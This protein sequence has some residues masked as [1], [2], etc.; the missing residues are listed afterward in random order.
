MVFVVIHRQLL[1]SLHENPVEASFNL[2]PSSPATLPEL[3]VAREVAHKTWP[4]LICEW[5]TSSHLIPSPAMPWQRWLAVVLDGPFIVIDGCWYTSPNWE[6]HTSNAINHRAVW[7]WYVKMNHP[8]ANKPIV[9]YLPESFEFCWITTFV[10]CH[11]IRVMLYIHLTQKS[12]CTADVLSYI[13]LEHAYTH[14]THTLSTCSLSG[15]RKHG[16]SI[17][18]DAVL[19]V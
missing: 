17:Y 16:P 5:Q 18:K 6:A 9:A 8:T 1:V 11:M 2:T 10:V 3:H 14:Y 7:V 12:S 4:F 15:I 13:S 19:L